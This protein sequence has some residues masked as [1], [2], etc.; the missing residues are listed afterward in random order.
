MKSQGKKAIR[1]L[2]CT[3]LCLALMPLAS[4]RYETNRYNDSNTLGS[5]LH[6][7]DETEQ[8]QPIPED[9]GV[10]LEY[11]KHTSE[12]LYLIITNSSAYD[13]KYGDGYNLSGNQWGSQGTIDREYDVLP[14]GEQREISVS[15]QGIGFGEFRIEK[16]IIVT[17]EDSNIEKTYRLFAEFSIENTTIPL[18]V[19]SAVFEA[20]KDFATPVGAVFLITNGFENGRLFFNKGFL[21][22]QNKEGVWQDLPIRSSGSFPQDE[23]SL[24][25]RQ[26][27]S[28]T[29]YWAWLY[30]ELLPGEYRLG[31][32]FVQRSDDG[33]ETQCNLFATFTLDGSPIPQSVEKEDGSTWLHPLG[34]ISTFRAEVTSLVGPDS[35]PVSFDN[36]T[37]LLVAA[38]DQPEVGWESGS[39]YYVWNNLSVI[40]LD[41]HG[42]Q[43]RFS[44]ISQGMTA[45]ITY[46]GLVL[47][48]DPAHI[49]GTLLIQLI[50]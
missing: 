16:N 22:Q 28:I 48:S 17:L 38:L 34:S 36:E 5:E 39:R 30:G 47:T 29:I 49:S 24:A 7:A 4:C 31:K 41:S 44:D 10:T 32:S 40:V 12:M 37:G 50:E 3:M 23:Y 9:F 20:D 26:V 25:S 1:S 11:E 21:L 42:K 6:N 15:I 43:I 19:R 14:F 33:T 27:L 45:D 8:P 2:F 13:I 35:H 46:S 18:S